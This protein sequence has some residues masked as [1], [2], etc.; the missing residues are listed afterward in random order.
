MISFFQS[1]HSY[2][3]KFYHTNV[4]S[5]WYLTSCTTPNQSFSGW[6]GF[7]PIIKSLPTHI[8]VKLGCNNMTQSVSPCSQLQ[9]YAVLVIWTE[10]GN[11]QDNRF[12]EEHDVSINMSYFTSTVQYSLQ[13]ISFKYQCFFLIGQGVTGLL[14]WTWLLLEIIMLTCHTKTWD[15]QK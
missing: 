6:E 12:N 7:L 5:N 14:Y 4:V 3:I 8:E 9:L 2:P 13:E 1:D 15:S 10:K 11:I